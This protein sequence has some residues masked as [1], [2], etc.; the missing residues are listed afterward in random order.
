MLIKRR[1]KMNG[2]MMKQNRGIWFIENKLAIIIVI[3]IMT[4]IITIIIIVIIIIIIIII[5]IIIITI[6]IIIISIK[7]IYNVRRIL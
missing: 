6:I 2:M 4:I 1:R 7:N 5:T 3:V